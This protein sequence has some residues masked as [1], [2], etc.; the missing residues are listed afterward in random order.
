MESQLKNRP[1][2][3]QFL[4]MKVGGNAHNLI[5][6]LCLQILFLEKREREGKKKNIKPQ[7]LRLIFLIIDDVVGGRVLTNSGNIF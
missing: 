6:L 5:G 1:K 4:D 2:R 3:H 7:R